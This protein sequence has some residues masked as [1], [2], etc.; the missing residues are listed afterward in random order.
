SLIDNGSE[1]EMFDY[2]QQAKNYRDGLDKSTRGALYTTYD[3][4]V[5]I[6]DQPGALLRVIE[7]LAEH[8]ISISNIE[9]LEIREGI[10]GVLRLSFQNENDR[11]LSQAI[12]KKND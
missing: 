4:F 6:F 8:D 10:T 3:I 11:Q 2:L 9:I 12:L 5:D 7:L 1:Q